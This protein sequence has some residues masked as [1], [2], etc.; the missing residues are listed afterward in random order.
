[1]IAEKKMDDQ[2]IGRKK[3]PM[4]ERIYDLSEMP[5]DHASSLKWTLLQFDQQPLL[6]R[7]KRERRYSRDSLCRVVERAAQENY[8]RTA[9]GRLPDGTIETF[10]N[11]DTFP[12]EFSSFLEQV[13]KGK[14][15]LS[16]FELR[17]IL[18]YGKGRRR[19]Y[20]QK[21]LH[22]I[23]SNPV[24]RRVVELFCR[25]SGDYVRLADE[26]RFHPIQNYTEIVGL[27]ELV[28]S[29]APR[30]VLEIGTS[31]GGSFYLFTRVAD[32]S[33]SLV[34]V[35]LRIKDKNLLQS[36]E[37][38]RQRITLIEASSTAPE[39]IGRIRRVLPDGVDFLFLDGDHSYEGIKTDFENYSPLVRPGGLIAF[40][41]IVEDNDSRYGVCTGGWSGGVPKFWKEV[42][43]RYRHA[44]F[45]DD[46]EQDGLGI[47]VLFIPGDDAWH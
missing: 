5:F 17:R 21:A 14:D 28:G 29:R 26:S 3:K 31:K 33:A 6:H 19:T 36:F 24:L 20:K 30:T 22:A 16:V 15:G 25:E 44:E 2:R 32:P 39:T 41:D 40:H 37:R 34:T 23:H 13:A 43:T 8:V 4:N 12:V 7:M 9:K 42:K 27:L 11:R 47:G 1:M 46:P 18:E 45:I 38:K 35:D 10:V